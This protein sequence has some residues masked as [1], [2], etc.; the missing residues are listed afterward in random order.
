M[1][2]LEISPDVNA[3]N[4]K[5]ELIR[6]VPVVPESKEFVESMLPLDIPFDELRLAIE[7]DFFSKV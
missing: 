5:Q 4:V 1:E 2:I 7:E 3:S 6:V